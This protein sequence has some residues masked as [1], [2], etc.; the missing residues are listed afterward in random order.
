MKKRS[1]YIYIGGILIAI[2]LFSP[3]FL[4]A[5]EAPIKFFDYPRLIEVRELL[6]LISHPSVR[7]IDMRT[8][9]PDYLNGHIPKAVYLHFENLRVP[10]KG[11]PAQ[12]PDRICLE[13]LLGDNLSLSNHMWVILYSEQSNPNATFL[14]WTLDY[15]G[16]RK[17]GILNGGWE[18]WMAENLP[19]TQEYPSLSPSKFFGKAILDTLAEKKWVLDRLTSKNVVIVDARSPRQ[20]SGEE[21]E[22][23]RRGH[24]PGA[25][26]IFWETTLEGDEVKVWKKKEDLEK[27]FAD[28]GVTKDKEVVVH[29]RLFHS[30]T[31]ASISSCPTVSGI[32]GRVVCGQ[33]PTR[34]DRHGSLKVIPQ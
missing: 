4:S 13:K 10:G 22:E 33:K 21:G 14:A 7:I 19:V 17:V 11:I 5:K 8:S 18:K 23:I 32:L 34:Q 31:C 9:L 26:N 16:H 28:S 1:A 25:K 2:I 29:C 27:L 20:Y 6:N 12:A 3:G 30:E 24:I 15:L